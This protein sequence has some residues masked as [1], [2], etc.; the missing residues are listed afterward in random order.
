MAVSM[1]LS[2]ASKERIAAY[3]LRVTRVSK[4]RVVN[5]WADAGRLAPRTD[6]VRQLGT[7][8]PALSF[9]PLELVLAANKLER[10]GVAHDVRAAHVAAGLAAD[11]ALTDLGGSES[12]ALQMGTV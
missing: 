2:S 12:V 7:T 3:S 5:L 11:A 10:L 9:Y 4:W 8:V 1:G 6:Q